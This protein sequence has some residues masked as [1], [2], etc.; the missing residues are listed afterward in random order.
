MIIQTRRYD[1]VAI[2]FANDHRRDSASLQFSEALACPSPQQ[3]SVLTQYKG[4]KGKGANHPP[5]LPS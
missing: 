3:I 5:P 1:F 2:V 4:F